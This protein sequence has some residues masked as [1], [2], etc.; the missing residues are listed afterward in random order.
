MMAPEKF[1]GT[2][3]SVTVADPEPLVEPVKVNWLAIYVIGFAGVA[4]MALPPPSRTRLPVRLACWWMM[5]L[6]GNLKLFTL[7]IVAHGEPDEMPELASL[8]P[9]PPT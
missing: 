3:L 6:A 7:A 9:A 4:L 1:T 5:L 8:A 2:L